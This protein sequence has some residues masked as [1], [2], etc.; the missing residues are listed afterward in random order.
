MEDGRLDPVAN[1]QPTFRGWMHFYLTPCL[2]YLEVCVTISLSLSSPLWEFWLTSTSYNVWLLLLG[3]MFMASKTNQILA[4]FW[5]L[6]PEIWP[7]CIWAFV[8]SKTSQWGVM[9]VWNSL[10]TKSNLVSSQTAVGCGPAGYAGSLWIGSVYLKVFT[11]DRIASV[12]RW[13]QNSWQIPE[14]VGLSIWGVNPRMELL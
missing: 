5:T 7:V 11:A 4:G 2:L 13:Q 6:P 10:Q 3:G 9:W 8:G 1:L 14:E 12:S